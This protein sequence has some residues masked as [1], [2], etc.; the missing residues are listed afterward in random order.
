MNGNL[1]IRSSFASRSGR[2][3]VAIAAVLSTTTVACGGGGG[4]GSGGAAAAATAGT[5]GAAPGAPPAQPGVPAPGPIPTTGARVG[6]NLGNVSYYS[7]DW[8]FVDVLKVAQVT[9]G[10]P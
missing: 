7:P 5:P 8:V 4:G 6:M 10:Y 2:L 3:I 9:D 1:T